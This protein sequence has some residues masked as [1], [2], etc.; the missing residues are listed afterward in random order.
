M[1]ATDS[2]LY[3]PRTVKRVAT[4][5]TGEQTPTR[6]MASPAAKVCLS[7]PASSGSSGG[8]ATDIEE[9]WQQMLLGR[10][11][12]EVQRL[13]LAAVKAV[14]RADPQLAAPT[15]R[16]SQTV[17]GGIPVLA[18]CWTTDAINSLIAS[19][20]LPRSILVP[21]QPMTTQSA[22]PGASPAPWLPP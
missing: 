15:T 9:Q 21:D 4:H 7:I 1:S 17:V 13:V 10:S 2:V 14:R 16:V 22:M 20:V 5:P 18:V 8:S 12:I 6:L 3:S 11:T 19:A